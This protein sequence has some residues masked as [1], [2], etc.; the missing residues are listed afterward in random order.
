MIDTTTKEETIM[1]LQHRIS[2]LLVEYDDLVKH[3]DARVMLAARDLAQE[4]KRLKKQLQ[5]IQ[6][7]VGNHGNGRLRRRD[8]C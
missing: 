3:F 5:D 4:N 8:G 7:I 1:R 6:K 2:V